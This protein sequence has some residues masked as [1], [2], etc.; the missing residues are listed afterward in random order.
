M[1]CGVPMDNEIIRDVR[2]AIVRAAGPEII[3]AIREAQENFRRMSENWTDE[4]WCDWALGETEI[5]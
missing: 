1:S 4:E 3:Q 5:G 2:E